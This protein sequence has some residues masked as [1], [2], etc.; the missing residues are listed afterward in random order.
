MPEVPKPAIL[1]WGSYVP[2][3]VLTNFDLEKMVDTSDE[4]IQTRTGISERRI[5]NNGVA[6]S[7]LAINAAR[8]AL[9]TAQCRPE[10]IDLIV[11]ATVTPDSPLPA[12]ACRVQTAIGASNAAAFDLA[13]A[14]SGFIYGLSVAS[15]M[16]S[17]GVSH[18]ALVIGSETLSKVTNYKDR[19]SCILFGDGAGAVVVGPSSGRGEI[20]YNSI[21]ADGSGADLMMIPAGGSRLPTTPETVADRLHYIRFQ[22][23]EVFKF[24]V[25][26]MVECIHNA[27][28]SCGYRDDEVSLIVPHQVNQRILAAA[29]DRLRL[30]MDRI[31][32][33]IN[34]FGN[35]SSAS[36]PIALDEAARNGRLKP[37]DLVVLVAFGGGLTWGASLV[38]W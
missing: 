34:R 26:K 35:T 5:V 12:T 1:G 4:W 25:V 23:R 21:G 13:A 6:C 8:K 2:D 30:P 18:R 3:T 33:N 38:R 31:Y 7:D 28:E 10:D 16:V 29:A 27:L 32:S 11:L 36:V 9:E 19:T 15:S 22:G 20:L 24:A 14:C 17:A 37:G